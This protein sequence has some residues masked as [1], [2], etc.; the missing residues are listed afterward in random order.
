MAHAWFTRI[1]LTAWILPMFFTISKAE[2]QYVIDYSIHQQYVSPR[3]LGMGNAFVA[4]A[5]DYNALFYNPAGLGRLEE[6]EINLGIAASMDSKFPKLYDDIKSTSSTSKTQDMVNLLS[7]NFGNY[8]S[9]RPTIG[10]IWAR[11][12]WAF[13]IIPVD[14]ELN[15]SV[16]QLGGASVDLIANQDSTIAYGRGWDVHWF[17][18]DRMSLGFTTKAIYRAYYN[19]EIQAGDL[20]INPNLLRSQD[21]Q[22]GF[23]FDADFGMLYSMKVA[24]TSVLRYLRPSLGFTIRNIFDYGFNQN[25]HFIDKNSSGQ[26]PNLG[27]R[28]DLGSAFEL[29]DFWIFKTRFLA[30]MRDMGAP[31]FTTGKGL[32]LGAEFLWK[33]R[34][35]WQGGWRVGT[36]QGYFTAGFT[37]LFGM[38]QLDLATYAEE[39]GTSNSPIASRRYV[40]KAS[41]DW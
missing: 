31:N 9:A 4:L 16:H 24:D 23:T 17:Q 11:P 25:F 30:D 13:A 34:S 8:Y 41:L 27:R 37:A 35:W 33:V 28:Y 12:K 40:A 18:Q 38:F 39:M 32:H 20:A 14:L 21:A 10:G 5:D 2:A 22:E 7:N 19:K 29:P 3:A 26:P 36:N 6:A 15:L 1:G